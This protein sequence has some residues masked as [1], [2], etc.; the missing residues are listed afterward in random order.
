MTFRLNRRTF[1]RGALGVTVG[2]PVL[3]CM[4]DGNGTAY[5]QS[6]PLPRRFVLV[7]AGQSLGGDGWER[8]K[9]VVAGNRITEGGHFI[10]PATS[11]ANWEMTTPL[12]PLQDLR[13]DLSI[14]SG[15]KIP[16]SKTSAEVADVPP[17]GAF[18]DFH[19]G[20]SGPLLC[21]TR[22]QSASF[23]CR[24]ITSDQVVANL[25]KGKTAIDS[26]VFRAQ[27]SWYL[28]GSSYSGRQ[29]ISYG[30]GGAKIEAQTS[31]QIAFRSLF[32]NTKP[33]G[34]GSAAAQ[35][36]FALRGKR[37]VLD[38]ILAK[39]QRLVSQVGAADKVRLDQHFE[40]LR[41]LEQ[42]ISAM[43]SMSGAGCVVP[44]DPGV[45]SP[46]GGDNAGADSSSIAT[47]T[48]YSGED[49]RARVMAD[50]IH[51]AFVCDLTRVATLQI[52]TFQ[53]HM[54]VYT[55]T[56]ALGMAIQADLHECGHN[57]DANNRGQL[58][59][60]TCLK[61]H[62]SIYARLL[63]K[64]KSTTEGAGTTLDNTVALFVPEGGHG[65]QLNDA[66]SMWQTH[67]VEDMVMLV[68]G[69]A[70]G[71]KPGNHIASG[72]VHPG[73]CLVSAM[74]AAGVMG[75]SFGEVNGNIPALFG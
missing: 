16:F 13:S 63:Q 17:G 33:S 3:E 15:M 41:A 10:A 20:G 48:G 45:D 2:L 22:S 27:P 31:P 58:A 14:V 66:T 73:N 44:T 49:A 53:S 21:G 35:L 43:P 67:S 65:L 11:G 55:V 74:Q 4:L 56:E 25:N 57:G 1:L 54:N 68:G 12:E 9:S 8:D 23:M 24:T 75:D 6:N 42:R 37:S 46:I 7:F 26:L 50:L 29:Y 32:Q 47:N 72:G 71:L 40:E 69:R 5:A 18:R 70:G 62:V 59:V 34:S 30:D 36:D 64:L 28:G 19:G 38:L 52:T 60:S 61:W 51:M 39:R